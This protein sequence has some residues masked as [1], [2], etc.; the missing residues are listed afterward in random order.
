M[1]LAWRGSCQSGDVGLAGCT[2]GEDHEGSEGM[3]RTG[4][5]DVGG[6]ELGMEAGEGMRCMAGVRS[7]WARRLKRDPDRSINGR[8]KLRLHFTVFT[9]LGFSVQQEVIPAAMDISI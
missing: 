8:K 2:T 7:A 9:A 4:S 3:G 5:V 6:F 1:T